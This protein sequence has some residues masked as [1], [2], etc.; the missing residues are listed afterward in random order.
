MSSPSSADIKSFLQDDTWRQMFDGFSLTKGKKL[1]QPKYI[2]SVT[3]E[4][5]ESGDWEVV[6]FVMEPDGHQHESMAKWL[7][8]PVVIVT[9]ELSAPIM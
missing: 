4:L 1:S 8:T 2:S 5:L 6:S 7:V 9:N 3:A